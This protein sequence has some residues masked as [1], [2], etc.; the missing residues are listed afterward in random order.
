VFSF[1]SDGVPP[2]EPARGRWDG[3]VLR[4][5]RRTARGEARYTLEFSADQFEYSIETRPDGEDRFSTL[6]TAVYIRAD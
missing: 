4:L 6:L 1:D 3:D 2:L 5:V